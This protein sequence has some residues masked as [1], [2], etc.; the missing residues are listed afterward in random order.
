MTHE[1]QITFK[2]CLSF[3]KDTTCRL[4]YQDAVLTLFLHTL[5]MLGD[6]QC[7]LWSMDPNRLVFASLEGGADVG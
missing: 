2:N 1:M 4:I 3:E 6:T 7:I 5:S